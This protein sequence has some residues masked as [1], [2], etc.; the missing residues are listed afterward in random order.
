M[1]YAKTVPTKLFNES[2]GLWENGPD[3]LLTKNSF[4]HAVEQGTNT[5]VWMSDGTFIMVGQDLSTIE[6]FLNS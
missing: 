4:S 2:T 6:T 3:V 1:P 5:Q